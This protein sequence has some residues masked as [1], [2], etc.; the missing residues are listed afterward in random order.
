M[1]TKTIT[2]FSEL[3]VAKAEIS[4]RRPLAFLVSSAMAGAYVGIGIILI[5]GLGQAIDPA[6]RSLVMG[7]SFGIALTLVV[8]AGSDLFTGHTM[9]MTL[10][11]LRG[12]I[13]PASLGRTWAFSWAGN[14]LG[15]VLLAFIFKLGGGGAILKDGADLI[16]NASAA[17]MNAPAL[18]LVARA[19]LC[20]WLVC[21]AL[22]TGARTTSDAAKCILIFWCLFAFIACGF[23]HSVANMTVFSVA[24][25]GH[26]P[27]NVTI[28][29]M[30]YNLL[31]VTIGNVIGGA[32]FVALGY[33]LAN[34]ETAPV[35]RFDAQA[36]TAADPAVSR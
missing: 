32:V 1:Y 34:A 24:L 16:Y 14:L 10:G 17:K 6:W 9:F 13:K 33:W 23:E 27:A 5:F 15:A 29:G 11:L 21:L 4:A 7:T 19:A 28:G 20:N 22:W 2:T 36:A 18:Q 26:P 25:L 31:F 30:A 12:A 3:A 35:K 8:F